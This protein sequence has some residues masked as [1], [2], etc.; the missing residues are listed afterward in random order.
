MASRSEVVDAE[1]FD[2]PSWIRA[3]RQQFRYI[4]MRSARDW[5][6]VPDGAE[7]YEKHFMT[8]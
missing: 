5:S 2:D 7:R 4:F 1:T 8:G 3:D 6:R